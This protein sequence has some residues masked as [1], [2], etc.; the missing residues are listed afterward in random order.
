MIDYYDGN[1]FGVRIDLLIS[2][3]CKIK[4]YI[5]LKRNLYYSETL[6]SI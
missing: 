5:N 1:Y 2:T 4:H 6:Q 3:D